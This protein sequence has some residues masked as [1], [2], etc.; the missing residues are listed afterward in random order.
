MNKKKEFE[1]LIKMWEVLNKFVIVIDL[2]LIF[3]DVSRESEYMFCFS[4]E[5]K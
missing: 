2:I 5:V 4:L 1:D 3:G